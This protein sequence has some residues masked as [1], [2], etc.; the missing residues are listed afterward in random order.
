M[1][2]KTPK[3]DKTVVN[4]YGSWNTQGNCM[5]CRAASAI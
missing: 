3:F 5:G 1:E 2:K 4:Y